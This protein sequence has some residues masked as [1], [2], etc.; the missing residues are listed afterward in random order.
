MAN[1]TDTEVLRAPRDLSSGG[2][3]SKITRS[4]SRK[5]KAQ[6]S[7]PLPGIDVPFLG[8]NIPPN[9]SSK[10]THPRP[11]FQRNPTP[12]AAPI[13]LKPAPSDLSVASPTEPPRSAGESHDA[14]K[15]AQMTLSKSVGATPSN[16]DQIPHVAGAQGAAPG[17]Q[18]PTAIYHHIHEVSNK[19]IATLDYMRKASVDCTDMYELC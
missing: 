7:I 6:P 19:R 13:S 14:A 8:P 16:E 17:S 12:P 4:P 2:F 1:V 3:L 10:R 9:A 11:G 15:T 18:N 5:H